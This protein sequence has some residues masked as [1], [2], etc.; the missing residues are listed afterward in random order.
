MAKPVP[1]PASAKTEAVQMLSLGYSQ[2]DIAARLGVTQQAVSAW[3]RDPIILERVRKTTLE[4]VIPAYSKALDVMLKQ[5]DSDMPWIQQGAA[6]DILTR[7]HELVTGQSNRD[8]VITL[9]GAPTLGMPDSDTVSAN[10]PENIDI[11]T[12]DA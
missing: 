5:L 1:I 10:M 7:Y 2:S 3:S 4:R 11:S 9:A 8:I 12:D 6:R